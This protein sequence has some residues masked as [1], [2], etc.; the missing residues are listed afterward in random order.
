M[1]VRVF[2][3][4]FKNKT[5]YDIRIE[6]ESATVQD[7]L[8]A[9]NAY[10]DDEKLVRGANL[11]A[12]KG[13]DGCCR[14]RLPLTYIDVL[15]MMPAPGVQA[16]ITGARPPLLEFLAKFGHVCV[17]GP[18]VDITFGRKPHGACSWL[19]D[20][21]GCCGNYARRP[22]V[23]Q[24][25][26]CSPSSKQAREL[27]SVIINQGM[28]ELVRQAMLAADKAGTGMIMHE[29][30]DPAIESA[31]WPEN[32]FSGKTSYDQVLLAELCNGKLWLEL[33]SEE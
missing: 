29:A 11:T 8:E 33:R 7:Y 24:S 18:A 5:G 1:Q 16:G 22:L 10:I 26:I 6:T 12:C 30:Y 27:R 4:Q 15:T 23:C 3:R 17:E 14:E 28:D 9:I 21:T 31:D 20:E 13:C 32:P 2:S 25:F 19:E